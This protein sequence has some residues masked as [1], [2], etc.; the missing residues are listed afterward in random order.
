[1]SSRNIFICYR[2]DDAEGYAG[3]IYDRLVARFPGRIFRDVDHI[4]PG[5]NFVTVIQERI[6]ACHVLL[7]IIGRD[8]LTITEASTKRRRLDLPNDYVRNEI[9]TALQR[10]IVVIPVLVRGATMPSGEQLPPDIAALSTRSAIEITE[11]DFD[12]DVRRLIAAIEYALGETQ[13]A[14]PVARTTNTRRNT[15]LITG[16]LGAIAA[17]IVS[18]LV[19]LGIIGSGLESNPTPTPEVAEAPGSTY[20]P[21]E[22]GATQ[23]NP[24]RSWRVQVE[25]QPE[26]QLDM[27]LPLPNHYQASNELFR[28]EGTWSYTSPYLRLEGYIQYRGK[29]R[30]P[31]AGTVKIDAWDGSRFV[32]TV[33]DTE[34]SGSR[35]VS[36]KPN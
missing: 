12:H 32:G 11:T 14:P 22:A 21:K 20:R 18:F 15:C 4:N 26:F 31:Y 33:T 24:A 19:I 23:F 34:A 16:I 29:E 25:G 28:S 5:A 27:D 13:H 17:V 7:A 3:R 2:R 30:Q 9:A 6:G 8:W 10:N 35:R 1:M 36:F